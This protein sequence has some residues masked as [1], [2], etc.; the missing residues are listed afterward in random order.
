M[1]DTLT[2]TGTE[3]DPVSTTR[4]QAESIQDW[5]NRHKDAITSAG[6]PTGPLATTWNAGECF[7]ETEKGNRS[8]AEFID[9]HILDISTEM[10]NCEPAS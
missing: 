8:E 1:T 5:T 6:A 4:Q 3:S 9:Q 2:T 10:V 7:A